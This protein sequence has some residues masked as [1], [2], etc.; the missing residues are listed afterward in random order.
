MAAYD[1]LTAL[2]REIALLTSTEALLSWDQETYMP[3]GA[4]DHRARQLAYLNGK[5]H[6]LATSTAFRRL[7]DKAEADGDPLRAGNL[8]ELRRQYERAVRLPQRL[9]QEESTVC[10]H[11]KA[12]WTEARRQSDF[13]G[14][15]PHLQAL[16]DLA[17][18]KAELWGY[19]D[20]PYD[21]LLET[22]ERGARTRDIA[23]LFERLRP[24]LAG[25]AR[26]A[27]ARSARR[28]TDLLRGRYPVAKQQQLNAEIAASIGFDLNC[29]RIDTTAHPFC[30]T[31]GPRD[32]R[33]TTRYDER[34]SGSP[35]RAPRHCAGLERGH[36]GPRV[37]EPALGEPSG[38][39]TG[40]L[41]PLR[42]PVARA[43]SGAD[44]GAVR[45]RPRAGGRARGAD[46]NPGRGR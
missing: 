41:A 35:G 18:R 46:P 17:R 37:A 39:R 19:A 42:P 2:A 21:A 12:A 34:D 38:P 6:A 16:V 22:Y 7:L 23:A 30:T 31:L 33:L 20:E 45:R 32:V 10:A 15:A 44:G 43:V 36:G 13:S 14:F 5:A 8:R 3:A 29:G 25:I 26:E 28:K 4:L 9:V 27:V 11:A 1:S 24:E 40:I